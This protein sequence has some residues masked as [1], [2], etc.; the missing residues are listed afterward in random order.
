MHKHIPLVSF[1]LLAC[2]FSISVLGQAFPDSRTDGRYVTVNNAKLWVVTVGKGDPL[3]L[4]SGGPGSAHI[5]MRQFDTLAKDNMLIYY[6]G[7]GRGKSDT[8][9]N[10]SEYTLARD[11]EDLEG[12]RIALHLNKIN[13]LGHSF[14]GVVA[15]GYAL[16]YPQNVM[17]L[18]LANTFHSSVMWQKNDDNSNHEIKT[19]YPEV[20]DTLMK[21]RNKGNVSSDPKCQAIYGLIPYGFLYSYNPENFISGG[22]PYPNFFNTKLYYQMVGRDGDFT[23]SSDIGAFDYRTKLKNLAMPVLIYGG[24]YDKVAVPEMMI[25]FRQYCPQAQFIIFEKSGHN[26]QVEEPKKLFAFLEAFL[27]Y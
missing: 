14:G 22:V 25:K 24:R 3:V 1:L 7:Y 6:D 19:N 11:I 4:I 17:H 23:V 8:A 10:V 5:Y 16:K 2:S 21:L 20:W 13:V 12:L 26:P 27:S 15:Q 18:V 9:K